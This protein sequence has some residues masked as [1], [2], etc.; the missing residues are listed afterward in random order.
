MASWL[1]SNCV[2]PKIRCELS[3]LL[4]FMGKGQFLCYEFL[5]TI[6]SVA[7]KYIGSSV[8]NESY[9]FEDLGSTVDNESYVF[10]DLGTL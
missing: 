9:V 10:E 2:V 8:D 6:N 5:W 4:D 3:Y 1:E 7:T